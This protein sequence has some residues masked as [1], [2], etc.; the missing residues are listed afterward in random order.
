MGDIRFVKIIISQKS[1]RTDK[2]YTYGVPEKM[3]DKIAL[4]SRVIVPFG[5]GNRLIEG[6]LVDILDSPDISLSK[7]KYIKHI[8]DEQ[9]IL[10]AKSIALCRWMR[11]TYTCRWMDAIQCVIP[12]GS[13]IKTQRKINLTEN[14]SSKLLND[15]QISSIG[16]R[17]L[18]LLYKQKGSVKENFLKDIL[19]SDNINQG[20]KELKKK[21]LI[22]ITNVF[23]SYV[24]PV[25]EKIIR[26]SPVK[27]VDEIKEKLSKNARKQ[28]A[29]VDYLKK[30]GDT[31]WP[32]LRDVLNTSMSTIRTLKKKGFVEIFLQEKLRKPYQNMKVLPSIS[33]DLTEEQIY[34]QNR[35]IPY[36][37]SNRR[38]AFLIHGVTGSGKT[39]VYMQLM[40]ETLK[41]SKQAIL[42]LPEIALTTQMIERFKG[43]FGD[44]VAILHSRLSL[45]ERYDEWRRI[46]DGKVKIAIGARSAVFAPFDQLG[47]IIIDEEHE[48]TYKS[49]HSPKYNA[50]EVAEFRCY[51]NDAVLILGSATPSI[52]TYTKALKNRYQKIDMKYRYNKNPLPEVEVID[53][54]KE[55]SKGNKS[56]F[57]RVLYEE[58]Q[59]CLSKGEQVLLFL[60]RRG[61]ST[62]ISCR[63]CGYVLRCPHCDISLTYHEH[64][65]KVSCH[66]CDFTAQ[67]PTVCPECSSKYIKYF[68]IG[69]EKIETLTQKYFPQARVARLDLDTTSRKGAMEKLLNDF[70]KKKIDILIGTQ[71]IAKGLDF[72]NV[73]LVGVIAA[74]T[75]LNLPD[76]RAAERTFQLITQVAGRAGRGELLGKVIVQTYEP[77]H[78]SIV[79]AKNYDYDLFYKQE[80]MLRKEFFY[81][82]YSVLFHVLFTGVERSK[83]ILVAK[84]FE[85]MLR[86]ALALKAVNLKWVSNGVH[87]APLEKVKRK[88]RWQ[89]IIKTKP[90]DR[91]IFRRIINNIRCDLESKYENTDFKNV[92]ISFD[93]N[94]YSMI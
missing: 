1:D 3:Q 64:G 68:G 63:S 27:S 56:I 11:E 58:I 14:F 32:E 8:V 34:A 43:R 80:I 91:N 87:S 72:P 88:Y 94:P 39:E 52:E 17:I 12:A 51:Q 76:F 10:S 5:K 31:E 66:Y 57:S 60:N 71:M 70:K 47:L 35:I 30:N 16:K 74:D 33:P 28:R 21:R 41:R 62:F 24:N 73:T 25:Q 4:G 55:L 53:M 42:L 85:K 38:A 18:K 46:K 15:E 20:F 9:P 61:Y 29:I 86:R 78:Y 23:T 75:N 79:S 2:E 50:I 67:P 45:G 84:K 82:P 48:Y 93:I 90:V 92:D 36:I 19:K 40:V 89:L 77:D 44:K 69:T 22:E 83:V 13:S 26:L 59:S 54:R 7:I 81:P 65:H 37:Q 49:E 6:F